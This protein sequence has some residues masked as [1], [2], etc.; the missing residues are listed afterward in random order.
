MTDIACDALQFQAAKKS[1][2]DK[3]AKQVR[4]GSVRSCA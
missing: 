4:L 3:L 1:V 2:E